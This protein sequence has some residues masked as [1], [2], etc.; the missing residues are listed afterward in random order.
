[1][2]VCK[3]IL[4]CSLL[5]SAHSN[6]PGSDVMA[7]VTRKWW[8][9][10]TGEEEKEPMDSS[11]DSKRFPGGLGDDA[12]TELLFLIDIVHICTV[13][14]TDWVSNNSSW[15]QQQPMYMLM[16]KVLMLIIN[17]IICCMGFP[18]PPF[19][20]ITGVMQRGWASSEISEDFQTTK[21]QLFMA[22]SWLWEQRYE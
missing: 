5:I 16:Y 22:E 13:Y 21:H 12:W 8:N 7:M 19:R 3:P 10:S 17:P 1:M 2:V 18:S 15:F 6:V 9:I 11:W 4:N 14:S 20:T